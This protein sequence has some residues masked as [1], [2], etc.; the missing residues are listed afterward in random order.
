MTTLLGSGLDLGP[1][2]DTVEVR[3]CLLWFLAGTGIAIGRGSEVRIEGGRV[4]GP[5]L[6]NDSSVGIHV[7]GNNGGVHIDSTDVI[8]LHVG[9]L[10][11]DTLGV[12]S[13]REIFITQATMDSDGRGLEVWDNSYVSVSGCWAASSDQENIWVSPDSHGALLVISG[14]TIFNAGALGGDPS[15]GQCNGITVNAGSFMLTGAAVRFNK[16]IG[17]WAPGSAANYVVSSNQIFS[18]GQGAVLGGDA[19]T[20]TGNVFHDNARASVLGQSARAVI[21]NN[22]FNSQ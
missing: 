3:G 1:V 21:A 12:G 5:G 17:V 11:R 22:A 13:N 10:L 2:T 8:G 14:G 16:G 19:Y 7:R 15:R 6:R 9:V 20:V 4:I 18:N